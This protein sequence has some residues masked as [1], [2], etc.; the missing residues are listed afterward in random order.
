MLEIDANILK[1]EAPPIPNERV[2]KL[3]PVSL[4]AV[5]FFQYNVA[6]QEIENYQ[7]ENLQEN[8]DPVGELL[9]KAS[10]PEYKDCEKVY[11]DNFKALATI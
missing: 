11:Q 9:Q 4:P 2:D 6:Q 5:E 8:Q 1:G 7:M 3:L 10:I